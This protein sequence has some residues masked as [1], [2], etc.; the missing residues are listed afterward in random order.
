MASNAP[1]IGNAVGRAAPGLLLSLDVGEFYPP[2]EHGG[3]IGESDQMSVG[4]EG[5]RWLIDLMASCNVL[6][7][8]FCTAHFA[9]TPGFDYAGIGGW[10]RNRQPRHVPQ[11]L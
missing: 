1:V 9:R 5:T 11:P 10:A 4:A 3:H 8:L 6:S 7:T 2:R